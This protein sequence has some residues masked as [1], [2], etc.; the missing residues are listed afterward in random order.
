MRLGGSDQIGLVDAVGGLWLALA[1][2]QGL[3]RR[4]AFKV[5]TR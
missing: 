4:L 5:L 2:G 1:L 3:G